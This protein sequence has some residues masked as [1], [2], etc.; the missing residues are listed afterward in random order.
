[1]KNFGTAEVP[2]ATA[3]I[4]EQDD[5]VFKPLLAFLRSNDAVRIVGE[6][7]TLP[8]AIIAGLG[9]ELNPDLVILLQSYS[10]QFAQD[11]V[12]QL[13]GLL[14]NDRVL[15]CYGPWCIADDR[16]HA[17]WPIANRVPIESAEP[18]I[19][20]ELQDLVLGAAP[21]SP[22]AA[23]E[24]VYSHRARSLKPWPSSVSTNGTV[25]VVS[26]DVSLR[27]TVV[28]ICADLGHHA[29]A[30]RCETTAITR[31]LDGFSSTP[32]FVIIDFDSLSDSSGDPHI[33]VK[34][35]TAASVVIGM[36]MIAERPPAAG[37]IT[38]IV[39]KTE[40]LSQLTWLLTA[41]SV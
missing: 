20:A 37:A 8:S 21:L 13:I 39:E 23:G 35:F 33:I 25:L 34:R 10:A 4:G 6:Y 30:A 19:A 22:M 26:D 32:R 11:D 31:S 14:L 28:G 16:S 15:C 38:H 3:I 27:N 29:A 12:N 9:L 18:I 17:I 7:P 5:C 1:M 40:L 36:T 24:E 2:A 41:G